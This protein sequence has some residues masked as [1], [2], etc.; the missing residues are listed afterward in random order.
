MSGKTLDISQFFELVMFWDE[1]A[2]L[3]DDVIEFG[4]YL[5]PN[6]DLP[7]GMPVSIGHQF[8]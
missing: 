1:T 8:V 5:G 4:N 3:P 7:D 2:T 6:I